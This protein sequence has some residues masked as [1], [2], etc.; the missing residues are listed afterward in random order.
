MHPGARASFLTQPPALLQP[1]RPERVDSL[2]SRAAA[3]AAKEDSIAEMAMFASVRA[4]TSRSRQ[5]RS[6][7]SPVEA[8]EASRASTVCARCSTSLVDANMAKLATRHSELWKRSSV[9]VSHRSSLPSRSA[10]GA[11]CSWA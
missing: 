6:F 2:S 7:T 3:W 1:P 5:E 8:V 11:T 10:R 9:F 4:S